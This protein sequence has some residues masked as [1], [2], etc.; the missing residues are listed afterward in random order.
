MIKRQISAQ[1]PERKNA[2]GNIVQVAVPAQVIEVNAPETVDEAVQMFS[3]NAI[4]SNAL[5][6]WDVTVQGI[7]RNAMKK[8]L[9]GEA[10]QRELGDLK[11]GVS[12]PR[13]AVDNEQL[14]YTQY[15]N[16]SAEKKAEM[17]KKLE[18]LRAA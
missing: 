17:L 1:V 16:A 4:L 2:E 12:R 15:L 8:G 3:E 10:L 6:H 14:F 18:E 7:M 9:V 5:A 11:M 13:V